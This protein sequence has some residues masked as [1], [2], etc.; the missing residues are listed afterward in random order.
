[1]PSARTAA[2]NHSS[3]RWLFLPGLSWEPG[4]IRTTTFF[5]RNDTDVPTDAAVALH[6]EPIPQAGIDDLVTMS[7]GTAMRTL[8]KR[9][10]SMARLRLGPLTTLRVSHLLLGIRF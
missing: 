6:R 2:A 9:A 10:A 1:M 7:A 5:V 4:D 3:G 8:A